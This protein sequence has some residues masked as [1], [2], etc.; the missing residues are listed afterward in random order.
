LEYLSISLPLFLFVHVIMKVCS[1]LVLGLPWF[2]HFC[3]SST[4]VVGEDDCLSSMCGDRSAIPGD[5]AL[6]LLQRKASY[7]VVQEVATQADNNHEVG[8]ANAALSSPCDNKPCLGSINLAQTDSGLAAW[9]LETHRY[10]PVQRFVSLL[11]CICVL[12]LV[13]MGLCGGDG[14]KVPD[15][16]G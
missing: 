9:K 11:A 4:T 1:V 3:C 2:V 6:A 13:V 10:L 12:V 14:I 15:S 5:D 7:M 8:L 16:R